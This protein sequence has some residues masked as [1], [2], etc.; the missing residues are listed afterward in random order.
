M[1]TN[2]EHKNRIESLQLLLQTAKKDIDKVNALNNLGWELTIDANF[3]KSKEYFTIAEQIAQK[4]G[5]REGLADSLC[6][7]GRLY[8]FEGDFV[9]SLEYQFNAL[10]IREEINDKKG[11]SYS[12][13]YL[14]DIYLSQGDLSDDLLAKE[15]YFNKALEQFYKSLKVAVEIEDKKKV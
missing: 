6:Y 3:V 14:G 12:L 8:E 11:I 9:H 10:K 4:I 2:T 13:H 7:L 5:F 15:E 1:T